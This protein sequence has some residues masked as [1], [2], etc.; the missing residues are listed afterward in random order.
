MRTRLLA[1]IVLFLVSTLII[2]CGGPSGGTAVKNR[3][4]TIIVGAETDIEGGDPIHAAALAT[5]RVL[6]NIYDSLVE[7]KLGSTD[8]EPSLAESWTISDDHKQYTFKLRQGI[9]FHDGEPF[10]AKA[11]EFAFRRAFDKDFQYYDKANTVG[12]FLVGL[13]NVEPLDDNTVRFTLKDPNGAFLEFLGYGAGRIVSP[14]AVRE[15]GNE[16]LADHPV[17]T[18]PF[19]FVSWDKGQKV[20][21]ERNPDYWK[22]NEPQADKLIF[23]PIPEPTARV[24]ALLTGQVNMIVVVPPDAIPQIKANAD[25]VYDQGPGDHYWFIVLNTR[26][27][28]F[29]DKRVRQAANYAIDKDGLAQN[30]LKG[31]AK[32]ATQAMPAANWSY[33]QNLHGYP[34]DPKKAKELLAE[35]GYPNG[36]KTKLIIPV[37]G[38]GMMVPVQMNEYIQ[39]NLRDVGIE[40]EIQSFEWVSYIGKWAQ[41]LDNDVSMNNQSIMSSEP[42][43]LNFLLHSKFTPPNGWN[44]GW[45]SNP[46]VDELLD[47]ALQAT[48]RA[49]RAKYYAEAED[50]IVDDA[51][52]IF[53]VNDLQ[54][55][56]YHKSV[57]G[58]VNNPAYVINF[59]PIY[60]EQ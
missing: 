30:I 8:I 1:L 20:E 44:T 29:K 56:A 42:Y 31:S 17:G 22:P 4:G 60:V 24:T 25:Y 5:T 47:K 33:D 23:V 51:P 18:G 35:A 28:P 38:S 6:R 36:F 55:M 43:V 12:F 7:F 53:V 2:G 58:Y 27:G 13:Q 59:D 11:V 48:D 16:W 57:K 19:R 45:Y 26:D 32:V 15:H 46:K 49:E 3:G 14:K 52:W 54:P 50:I 40:A 37:S 41:G 39:G 21:L 34:Y 10:N 9:K